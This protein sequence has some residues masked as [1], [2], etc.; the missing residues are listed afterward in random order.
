MQ[1]V[2][3]EPLRNARENYFRYGRLL[4]HGIKAER[5]R[6]LF[7]FSFLSI[8]TIGTR[9]QVTTYVVAP[10]ALSGHLECTWAP[11]PLVPNM[12]DANNAITDTA[13]FVDDG[14]TADS[15]G[16]G[17]LVNGAAIN[18]NIAVVYRGTCE[19]SQKA[20]NAQNAGARAVVVVNNTPGSPILMGEG[21]L[22]QSITIPVVMITDSMGAVL[23]NDILAGTAVL[24]LGP[25][26]ALTSAC[27]DVW[28]HLAHGYHVPGFNATYWVSAHNASSATTFN[29][30]GV[31]FDYD[32]TFTLVSTSAVPSVSTAGHLEWTVA[33]LA[34]LASEMITVEVQ[35]PPNPGLIGFNTVASMSAETSVPDDDP[36][37]DHYF[38]QPGFFG[39]FDPN[40]KQAQTQSLFSDT[41]YSQEDD[42][43]V[44]YTI[45]FQNTG[46]SPAT[47]VVLIDTLSVLFPYSPLHV[48]AASHTCTAERIGRLVRFAF[49]NIQLPDSASDPT[50]SQG[51][52]SFRMPL[53]P[54]YPVELPLGTVIAN[55]ADIYFDMNPP[56]RTDTS[57]LVV[58][59]TEGINETTGTSALLFPNPTSGQ[60]EVRLAGATDVQ[61][62]VVRSITGAELMRLRWPKGSPSFAFDVSA[63]APGLY[64]VD[65]SG[66]AERHIVR[67]LK[68]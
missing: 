56:I 17:A 33:A 42:R 68:E 31:S 32:P 25:V 30:V 38:V 43:Y 64:M 62:V 23:R 51:F 52:V 6:T 37:N 57:E 54:L 39:A 18:G 9:G 44:D 36:N 59:D 50:G 67:L 24:Y 45:R 49:A 55:A 12:N 19:F 7:L 61:E 29:N 60:V 34:P 21:T 53:N 4:S 35:V 5:L 2:F 11:W 20:L 16:C 41:V 66:A 8:A 22:G 46:N 27:E 40:D 3:Q 10:G 48:L 65:L 58:T 63:L 1:R 26:C 13:V 15:L 47:D 14:T 28:A